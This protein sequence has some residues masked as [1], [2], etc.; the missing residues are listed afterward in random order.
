SSLGMGFF[1]DDFA[2]IDLVEHR[3]GHDLPW[4]DLY[5]FASADPAETRHFIEAGDLTW[6]TVPEL[7]LRFFRPLGSA[8]LAFDDHAFGRTAVLW[9]LHSLAWF[10]ALLFAVRALFRRLLPPATAALALFV[11]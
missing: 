7:R 1:S 6:W 10:A 3:T 9:H 8:L 11:F 4:W 2:F 5:H